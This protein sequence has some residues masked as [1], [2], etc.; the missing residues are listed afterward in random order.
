[1]IPSS[2][3]IQSKHQSFVYTQ[4]NDQKFLFQTISFSVSQMVLSI[5]MYH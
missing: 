1:M 5:A 4:L 3:T 2:L